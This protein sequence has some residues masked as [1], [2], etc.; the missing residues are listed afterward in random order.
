MH[1]YKSFLN[2]LIPIIIYRV[3]VDVPEES[4]VGLHV[5]HLLLV[6]DFQYSWNLSADF[7]E[8]PNY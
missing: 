4:C 3:F 2:I 1:L 5:K 6:S 8:V 7:S